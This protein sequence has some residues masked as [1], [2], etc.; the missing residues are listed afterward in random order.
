VVDVDPLNEPAPVSEDQVT[1]A[2]LGSLLTV[3]VMSCVVFW[4][5]EKGCAGDRLMLIGPLIVML[6][7]LVVAV[8]PTESVNFTENG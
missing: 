4:S 7:P 8:L 6:K 5:I 1:P 3:A 2:L